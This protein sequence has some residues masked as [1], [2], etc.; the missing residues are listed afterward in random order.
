MAAIDDGLRSGPVHIIRRNKM[1][2]VVVSEDEYQRLTN[3]RAT[4]PPGATAVQWLLRQ[5]TTSKCSKKQ[6]DAALEA[7]RAW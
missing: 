5:P 6:I 7:E 3:Q 1:A 2:A 4:N